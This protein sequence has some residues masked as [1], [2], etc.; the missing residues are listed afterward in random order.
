MDFKDVLIFTK[1]DD[2]GKLVLPKSAILCVD[3]HMAK[4]WSKDNSPQE[5]ITRLLIEVEYAVSVHLQARHTVFQ[6]QV[7]HWIEVV[8]PLPIVL[9]MLQGSKAVDI[10][11]G[12]AK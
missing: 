1:K 11:F 2:K 12:D 4:N 7:G 8:E 9:G 6:G 10:L 3:T 5:E